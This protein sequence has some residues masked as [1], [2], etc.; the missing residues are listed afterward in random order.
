VAIDRHDIALLRLCSPGGA[1]MFTSRAAQESRAHS[2]FLMGLLERRSQV[3]KVSRNGRRTDIR[4]AY[5][6]TKTG[7]KALEDD[8]RTPEGTEVKR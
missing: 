6:R 5:R 3:Y 7:T 2:L 4:W 8:Q 1:Y